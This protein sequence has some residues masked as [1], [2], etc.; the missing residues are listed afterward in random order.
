MPWTKQNKEKTKRKYICKLSNVFTGNKKAKLFV[1]HH[2][3]F[4]AS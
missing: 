1:L 2:K 3:S 4:G